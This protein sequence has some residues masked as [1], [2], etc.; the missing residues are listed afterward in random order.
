[1]NRN[2]FFD[3][4]T[5]EVRTLLG[6]TARDKGYGDE[7]R[8]IVGSDHAAGEAIYKILRWKH[9]RNPEDLRKAAAWAFLLWLD[10]HTDYG[11]AAP[12]SEAPRTADNRPTDS[13]VRSAL[14]RDPTNPLLAELV[15]LRENEAKSEALPD[16]RAEQWTDHQTGATLTDEEV[17]AALQGERRHPRADRDEDEWP[18]EPTTPPLTERG[19]KIDALALELGVS[20]RDARRL[21]DARALVKTR[22]RV[23]G[24]AGK[25]FNRALETWKADKTF[26]KRRERELASEELNAAGLR[27]REARGELLHEETRILPSPRVVKVR[28]RE[29]EE[30]R[31]AFNQA[32]KAWQADPTSEKQRERERTDRELNAAGQRLK[33]A[34][35]E[36]ELQEHNATMPDANELEN[37][38]QREAFN[39]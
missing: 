15:R 17:E 28:E 36:L 8:Q 30:A 23:C 1:M 18:G 20:V 38:L 7:I 21:Y 12:R 2:D 35:T 31:K 11:D 27:L 34:K 39:R 4:F 29:C 16:A 37:R 26:E 14:R 32:F 9:K 3:Q 24:E 25:R 5:E 13:E 10:N 19:R 33:D 6:G 22:E